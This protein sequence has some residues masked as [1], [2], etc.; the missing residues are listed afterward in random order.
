MCL[1]R[2]LLIV[3]LLAGT[4]KFTVYI[5]DSNQYQV[6]PV[7]ADSSSTN[8]FTGGRFTPVPR[9]SAIDKDCT[10]FGKRMKPGKWLPGC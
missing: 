9:S 1:I 3:V 2:G 5:G 7:A 10:D 4:A 8:Y 6:A